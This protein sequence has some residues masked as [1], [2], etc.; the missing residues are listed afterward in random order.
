MD[1]PLFLSP[2]TAAQSE[3]VDEAM[4]D[5]E[6]TRR[7]TLQMLK[8]ASLKTREMLGAGPEHLKRLLRSSVLGWR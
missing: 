1:V 4:W 8:K 5:D 2:K 6:K 7:K 3:C